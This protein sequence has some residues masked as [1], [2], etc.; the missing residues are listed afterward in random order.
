M[1]ASDILEYE[2][3]QVLNVETGARFETYAICEKANSG[4]IIFYGPAARLGAPGD[5]VIVI[6]KAFLEENETGA[7]K[8]KVVYVDKNNKIIQKQ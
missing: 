1:D 3:V 6:A 7:L 2:V 5:I 4:R 8:P